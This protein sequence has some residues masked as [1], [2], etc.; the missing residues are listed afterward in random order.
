M[1]DDDEIRS[2]GAGDCAIVFALQRY[3]NRTMRLIELLHQCGVPMIIF[4]DSDLFPYEQW[5][6]ASSMRGSFIRWHSAR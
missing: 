6:T 4:S 1:A 3:P 5:P 2:A